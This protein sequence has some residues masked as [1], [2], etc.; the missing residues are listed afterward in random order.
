MFSSRINK[1]NPYRSKRIML[2][3][4]RVGRIAE[5]ILY[6]SSGGMGS[7]L[8]IARIMLYWHRVSSRV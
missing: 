7:R 5:N 4:M 6:P 8:N 2:Q 1:M 3:Y